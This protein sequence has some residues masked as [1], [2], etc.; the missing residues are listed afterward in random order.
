[1]FQIFKCG[2]RTT[3]GMWKDDFNFKV[4]Y[5]CPTCEMKNKKDVKVLHIGKKT[6]TV[7]K[8]VRG[9]P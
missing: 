9:R 4:N 8:I 3:V 1:M 7:R 5:N 6:L 2:H